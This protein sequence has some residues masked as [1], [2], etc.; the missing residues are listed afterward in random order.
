[1]DAEA[2]FDQFIQAGLYLR[3]WSPKTAVIYQRAFASLARSQRGTD[4]PAVELTK[5]RFETWV[6]GMRQA[7]L[8]PAGCNIYIRAM[9]AFAAWLREQNYITAPI[10]LGQVR[11]PQTQLVVFSDAEVSAILAHRPRRFTEVRLWTLVN[12]LVDTGVRIDE[13]LTLRTDRI[14]FDNLL[15]VVA[16]KGGRER[17]VPFSPELRRVLF[18]FQQLTKGRAVPRELL[19]CARSGGRLRYRNVH[20]DIKRLC[21]RLGIRGRHVRPHCFRH[22]F[23]TSYLRNGGD[24]YSLSRILGHTS[25]KTTEVYLRSLAAEQIA[26]V[27]RRVSPLARLVTRTGS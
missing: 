10:R 3:G 18:R 14:D 11:V 6:V 13:A 19:F 8:S 5:A 12:V 27:H 24:L 23:A 22:F 16:G 20:R 21:L 4:A 9:N 25:V 7:G 1:M 26:A 17:K 15:L 2:L